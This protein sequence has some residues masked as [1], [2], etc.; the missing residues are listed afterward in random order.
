VARR[1]LVTHDAVLRSGT[2]A[3]TEVDREIRDAACGFLEL[4]PAEAALASRAARRAYAR[5]QRIAARAMTRGRAV[6]IRVWRVNLECSWR[7]IAELAHAGWGAKWSPPSNQLA[8]L[9]LCRRAAALL[10][11][12]ALA[13]PWNHP[14]G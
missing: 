11:E 3:M 14:D 12:D 13:P 1:M 4:S 8:G 6:E 9:A 10:G 2:G 5:F 7:K